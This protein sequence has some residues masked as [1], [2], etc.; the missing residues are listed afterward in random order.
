MRA[1]CRSR[2]VA[3]AGKQLEQLLFA[4]AWRAVARPLAPDLEVLRHGQAGEDAAVLRDVAEPEAGDLVG[5]EGG[6]IVLVEAHRAGGGSNQ[7]HDRLERGRLACAV[8]AEERD[9]LARS[10][11]RGPRSNS[12]ARGRSRRATRGPQASPR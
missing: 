3:S 4:P 2:N 11:L 10:H 6:E 5:L 7:P 1:P 9:D 8:A 12:T